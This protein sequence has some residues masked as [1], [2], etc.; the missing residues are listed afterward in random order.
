M[1]KVG[2]LIKIE[3]WDHCTFSENKWRALSDYISLKPYKAVTVGFLLK[4]TKKYYIV[5][6]T[7]ADDG[8]QP[9]GTGEFLILKGAVIKV[10]GL[11]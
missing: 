5:A 7:I 11:K 8:I 1:P 10:K 4:E 3:W 6:A 2:E 9:T